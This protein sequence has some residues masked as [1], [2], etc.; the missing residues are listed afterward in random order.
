M[1]ALKESVYF[2]DTTQIYIEEIFPT[3]NTLQA[4]TGGTTS[5]LPDTNS[6]G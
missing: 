6:E 5:L 1:T 3:A 4:D 2:Q